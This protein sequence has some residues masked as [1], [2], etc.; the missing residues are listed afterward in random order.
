MLEAKH[1]NCRDLAEGSHLLTYI[2][3]C[4]SFDRDATISPSASLSRTLK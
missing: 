4:I 2:I 3:T 1:G